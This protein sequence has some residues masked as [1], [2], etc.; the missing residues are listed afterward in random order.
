MMRLG[1]LDLGL[2]RLQIKGKICFVLF[3]HFRVVSQNRPPCFVKRGKGTWF[4]KTDP[5]WIVRHFVP[6]R[7]PLTV[8]QNKVRSWPPRFVLWKISSDRPHRKI[9][10]KAHFPGLLVFWHPFHRGIQSICCR[11]GHS[12]M[13]VNAT[14]RRLAKGWWLLLLVLLQKTVWSQTSNNNPRSWSNFCKY[15]LKYSTGFLEIH[16]SQYL[17]CCL[18]SCLYGLLVIS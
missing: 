5:P 18:T 14:P 15:V 2:V 13:A 4:H 7:P 17:L 16:C 9:K 11:S 8:T 10:T 6:V 3:Q 1:A 12:T